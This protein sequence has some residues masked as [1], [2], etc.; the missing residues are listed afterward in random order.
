MTPSLMHTPGWRWASYVSYVRWTYEGLVIN[1][2]E[3]RTD[4]HATLTVC[5]HVCVCVCV[6]VC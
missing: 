2:F 4:F 5:V 1:E 3:G 6:C